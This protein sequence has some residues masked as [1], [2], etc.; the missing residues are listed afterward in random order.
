MI[1][2]QSPQ[3]QDNRLFLSTRAVNRMQN[4]MKQEAH[5]GNLMLRIVVE[6]GGCSGLQYHFKLDYQPQEGDRIFEQ[7]GVRLVVDDISFEYIKGS[8][9]DFTDQLI[10]ASFV[11]HNPNASSACGCG[12]S[13]SI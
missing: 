3:S 12:S 7:D 13:F 10:G 9:V 1:K 6:G 8:E 4:L 11:I 2:D 5:P